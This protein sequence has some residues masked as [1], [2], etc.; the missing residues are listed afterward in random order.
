LPTPQSPTKIT[1]NSAA[2]R[3]GVSEPVA[4]CL[5]GWSGT[6][7]AVTA[8]AAASAP[9]CADDFSSEQLGCTAVAATAAEAEAANESTTTGEEVAVI[10]RCIAGLERLALCC[11][12]SCTI[13][14]C[15]S[16][17]AT[18]CAVRPNLQY[19]A[20]RTNRLPKKQCN[21]ISMQTSARGVTCDRVKNTG[22]DLH[23]IRSSLPRWS[24]TRALLTW[25]L[26]AAAWSAVQ[27]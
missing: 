11:S 1:L 25:P 20:S 5:C 4:W 8:A 15:P 17:S 2:G 26:R 10:L 24:S 21:G 22:A 9:C 27:P 19:T 12:N 13:D 3:D 14:S 23:V 16:L 7:S 18:L 6:A